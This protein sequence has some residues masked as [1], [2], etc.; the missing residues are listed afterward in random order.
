MGGIGKTQLAV[1]YVYRYNESYPDGVFWVN[2]VDP[3]A[4]GLAQFGG[5]LHPELRG[6]SP[7]RQLQVACEELSRRREALL[8]F[9]NLEDPAQLARPVGSE[10]IPL[11]LAA[12]FFSPRDTGSLAGSTPSRSQCSPRSPL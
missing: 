4:Q 5:R 6:E 3:L 10:G 7:E 9:D 1:E 2:A 11:N 8:V 12:R